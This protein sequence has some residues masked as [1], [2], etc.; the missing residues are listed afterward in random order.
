MAITVSTE[1]EDM[2]LPGN[3]TQRVSWERTDGDR[4][5]ARV[6]L[7]S[8]LTFLSGL[9]QMALWL[10][11]AGGVSCWLSRPLVRWLHHRSSPPRRCA[12]AA[13]ADGHQ[14]GHMGTC[15]R[16]F[17]IG[18]NSSPGPTSFPLS[19]TLSSDIEDGFSLTQAESSVI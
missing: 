12:P 18:W 15:S 7:A 9:V 1:T 19:T 6:E 2:L 10:P 4:D 3:R 8:Q 17:S 14:G 11:G 16:A 5:A 13:P